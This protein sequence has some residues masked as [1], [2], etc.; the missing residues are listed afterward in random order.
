MHKRK[1]RLKTSYDKL[2]ANVQIYMNLK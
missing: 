1:D 2:D